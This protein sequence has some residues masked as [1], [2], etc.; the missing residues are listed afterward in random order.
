MA[1]RGKGTA[2]VA[3]AVNDAG[4]HTKPMVKRQRPKAWDAQSVL[5][6]LQ[7]PRYAG[8]SASKGQPGGWN[9]NPL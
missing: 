5:D 2:A 7:N 6:V 3:R 9:A 1:L 8:L 4:W